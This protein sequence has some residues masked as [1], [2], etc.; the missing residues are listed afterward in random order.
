MPYWLAAARDGQAEGVVTRFDPRFWTVN[1]PR[2]MM[3]AAT[4]PAP[5]TLRIDAAF[6]RQDD[7]AGV[8]WEAE[9]RHD[10]PLLR[11]ETARDFRGCR[12]A[13]RWRSAGVRALDRLDG[14]VLTIEGRDA[15]GQPRAWYVRLWNYAVGAPEDA[16]VA[17]DFA[18][19][20]GGFL[21]PQE[22]DPVWAGDVDRLVVSLVPPGH[23]GADAALAAPAEGWVELSDLR[24][25]GPGAVLAIGDAIVPEHGLGIATGYDDQYHL[26][27]ARVLRGALHLGYR[28][29]I[30]HYLG[31]SHYPRLDGAQVASL[32]GGALNVAAAAWHRDFATRAAALGYRVIWSLSYELLD[33][34]CP[35]AWKQRFADGTAALTGWTPPSALLSP[36]NGEAMA[37]LQAVARAVLAIGAAAGLG[38]R[39]QVGEPWWWTDAAGRP[40]LYDAAAVAAIAPAAIGS[41][42][43]GLSA[44]QQATLDRAGACLAASTAALTAAAKDAAPGCVTHLLA[45]LP[46]VLDPAAPEL[47]RANL[48]VGWA[49]PAFD[50]LQLED[51][52]WV[53][54][55]DAAASAA[56]AAAATA[57]LGYPA[58]AQ[59]Y[60][61]G[62]VLR[63]EDRALWG[64]IGAAADA[65]RARGASAFVWALPQVNRDGY[66][67]WD[68]EDEVQAFDDVLFPLALGA[69]AEV[70][71]GFQTQVVTGAGG[72]E[73][74]NV[75]WA[76]ARTRYD[77]GPGVRSEAD[78]AALLGFF[79]ARM[80]AARGFRLRD[81][82]DWT[83]TDE[84][85]GTGDGETLRFALAKTYGEARRRITRPVA[86]TV[87]VTVAGAPTQ[88]FAVAA[89]GWLVLDAAPAPGA[90]VTASFAFDVP[91]RFAED[92]LAVSRATHLAGEA[93]SVPLIELKEA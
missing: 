44:G 66:V 14:P 2:P 81:P 92:R 75:G 20:A 86:G 39:F 5:D 59:H 30:V 32:A 48:P 93:A 80:G 53:I 3:A 70:A 16:A 45:Y 8:I 27:P 65:A 63:T 10:H 74:R 78:V 19:V 38:P 21:H 29:S 15:G 43:A 25:D 11:Y 41:V 84:P 64:R 62:F 72:E 90:A 4:T 73:A 31:M 67:H 6:H 58:H 49:A 91:V 50:V 40:A 42:R 23:T 26:T 60:L 12:L 68:G 17:I 22:A 7:L 28:G 88:A 46:T 34:H 35:A 47:A 79:R 57:R 61:S 52:D 89:G 69:A 13:F 1:F 9:D 54:A 37:Y 76:E 24:C 56:G 36:A 71:P 55:G 85:V 18:H 77:V 33:R 51:Y 87:T 82:F 83:G